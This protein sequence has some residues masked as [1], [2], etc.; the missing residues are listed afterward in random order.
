MNLTLFIKVQPILTYC[1]MVVET[2]SDV[3]IDDRAELG[4]QPLRR[5]RPSAAVCPFCADR[6]ARVD[7]TSGRSRPEPGR[8]IELNRHAQEK[9]GSMF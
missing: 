3:F 6:Q 4:W 8:K 7:H 9:G 5:R 2:S 1:A